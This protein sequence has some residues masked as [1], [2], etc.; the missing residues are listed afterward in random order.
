VPRA[1]AQHA[2]ALPRRSTDRAAP[3]A[4]LAGVD[5][6]N[7]AD[8]RL[9]R[10][11]WAPPRT[12][13]DPLYLPH[14]S[15]EALTA[16]VAGNLAAP[17]YCS[18]VN[19]PPTSPKSVRSPSSPTPVRTFLRSPRSPLSVLCFTQGPSYLE[20]RRSDAPRACS[21]ASWVVFVP[22]G[23]EPEEEEGIGSLVFR[24]LDH[25]AIF[26]SNLVSR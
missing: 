5:L 7:P 8:P 22:V 1:L 21:C 17:S 18:S 10:R 9:F 2:A 3:A 23:N 4:T 15:I 20:P 12:P 6:R 16:Q 19:R 26:R 24:S 13:L 25:D 11:R 14:Q